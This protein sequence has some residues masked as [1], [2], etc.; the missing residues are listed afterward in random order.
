MA[1]YT[2]EQVDANA[3]AALGEAHVTALRGMRLAYAEAQKVDADLV[4]VRRHIGDHYPGGIT[5]LIK[6]ANGTGGRHNG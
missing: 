4:L 1:R 2:Q 3:F 6:A 5:A